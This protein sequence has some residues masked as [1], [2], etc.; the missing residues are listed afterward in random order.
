MDEQLVLL[1]LPLGLASAS[2]SRKI[3]P[4]EEAS[5]GNHYLSP[6]PSAWSKCV[7]RSFLSRHRNQKAPCLGACQSAW[8]FRS[9]SCLPVSHLF[10]RNCDQM[11]ESQGPDQ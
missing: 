3:Y 11:N 1:L 10:Y 4:I 5:P 2:S 6:S 9:C 8:S 7:S